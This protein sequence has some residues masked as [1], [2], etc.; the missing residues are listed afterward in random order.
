MPVR[1]SLV[2]G[3]F[4]LGAG[5][6]NQSV[7]TAPSFEI[8][9]SGNLWVQAL[10]DNGTKDV[11]PT[12]LPMGTWQLWLSASESVGFT[13]FT[14][15]ESGNFSLAGLAAVGNTLV[16]AMANFIDVPAGFGRLVYARASGGTA[17]RATLY[18][19]R[20]L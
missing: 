15:A 19:P 8:P 17:S 2:I 1:N 7:L 5:G 6:P 12:D 11:A 13:R 16:N 18:V 10:I 3:P 4:P 9:S 14:L 20:A